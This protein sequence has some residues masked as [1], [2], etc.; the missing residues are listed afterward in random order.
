MHR[1]YF[2]MQPA[3]NRNQFKIIFDKKSIDENRWNVCIA[4]R[5]DTLPSDTLYANSCCMILFFII[6]VMSYLYI[7]ALMLLKENVMNILYICKLKR[8]CLIISSGQTLF[9]N[10]LLLIP[11]DSHTKH[12]HMPM[13]LSKVLREPSETLPFDMIILKRFSRHWRENTTHMHH[14][15]RYTSFVERPD[16]RERAK[17]HS[18]SEISDLPS[19]IKGIVHLK[20]N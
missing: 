14:L 17:H 9:W 8:F 20:T 11:G 10:R 13:L 7:F 18:L 4:Y 2:Y 5:K 1:I 3:Y 6:I 19:A 12:T 15:C 16:S